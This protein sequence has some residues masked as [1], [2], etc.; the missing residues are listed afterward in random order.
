[1][2]SAL[3]RFEQVVG[4]PRP[5]PRDIVASW[6]R[7]ALAGVRPE[8]FEV[9]YQSDID[10]GGR[11][12]WAAAPIIE[13]VSDDLENTRIAL[14][15]TD[16]RARVLARSGEHDVARRLDRIQLAPG[17][18]YAEESIGTNA[19]G[20]AIVRRGAS[21]VQGPEHF[22][23]AL[24]AM[25]CTAITVTDPMS[26]RVLGVVDLTCAA[27]DVSPLMLPFA[28]R[29]AWE[30]EQRLIEDAAMGERLLRE[31]FLEACRTA[32]SPLVAVSE[33]TL[34]ISG[35]AE[36]LVQSSDREQLWPVVARALRSGR[37][38]SSHVLLETGRV[39]ALRCEP[40][41]DGTRPI[42][43][44]VHLDVGLDPAGAPSE[45]LLS[46]DTRAFGWSSLTRT[47]RIVAEH[48]AA[49]M[50]NAEVASRLIVSPHTID[51]HL[52]QL[53]RKLEVRSRVELTRI[54]V[55]HQ[56]L[57]HW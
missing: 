31:R 52:R 54:F 29:V 32:T 34:L 9:P 50:T 23:E 45:P 5:L 7:S 30:I 51:Y 25:A 36:G 35:A 17:F 55:E 57:S 39:V 11:L 12:T 21:V 49:G 8:R 15:L 48:V 22:S 37:P 16:E 41:V 53:F 10:D 18:V 1:V 6:Q 13:R 38:D 33:R 26:G 42:G 14:I 56:A 4:E 43:G 24:I 27:E 40:V 2:R 19:I 28:K 47:E 3:D 20:T 46:R 44:I